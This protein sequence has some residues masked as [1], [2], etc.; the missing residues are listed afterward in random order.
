MTPI[1]RIPTVGG[2]SWEVGVWGGGLDDVLREGNSFSAWV[3]FQ[4]C[5]R[6]LSEASSLLQSTC[7]TRPE[8]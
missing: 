5:P 8:A 3:W 6:R 1:S 2:G 7:V 4:S